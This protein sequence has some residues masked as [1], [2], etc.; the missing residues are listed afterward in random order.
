MKKT[1]A[2]VYAYLLSKE[3]SLL[4]VYIFLIDFIKEID[5]INNIARDNRTFLA[6]N[7]IN[8]EQ[9]TNV[10]HTEVN[11]HFVI[12]SKFSFS[13][14]DFDSFFSINCKRIKL[15]AAIPIIKHS[16]NDYIKWILA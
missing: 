16:K 10:N 3:K 8:K 4:S 15:I 13:I 11:L 12:V 5:G 7:S 1:A 2:P 14:L 9:I 6:K